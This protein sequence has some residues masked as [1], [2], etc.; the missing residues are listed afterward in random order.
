MANNGQGEADVPS[1]SELARMVGSTKE[2]YND[3][4]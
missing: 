4:R 2:P 1:F 3:Q